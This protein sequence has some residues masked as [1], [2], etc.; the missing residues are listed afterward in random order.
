MKKITLFLML[1]VVVI[2]FSQTQVILENPKYMYLH[3]DRNGDE[4]F[5]YSDETQLLPETKVKI[6]REGNT[7]V[8]SGF[9]EI[10]PTYYEI[11]ETRKMI[12]GGNDYYKVYEEESKM[13]FFFCIDNKDNVSVYSLNFRTVINYTKDFN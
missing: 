3:Q 10:E 4:I 8:I 12:K 2:S 5:D 6:V 7:F 13:Y 11:V 9:N 1:F